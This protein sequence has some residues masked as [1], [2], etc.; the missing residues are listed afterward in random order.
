M[1]EAIEDRLG[2]FVRQ[3]RHSINHSVAVADT[4]DTFYEST[5]A[6]T[7][8]VTAEPVSHTSGQDDSGLTVLAA[9]SHQDDEPFTGKLQRDRG[10]ND[11]YVKLYS[12]ALIEFDIDDAVSDHQLGQLAYAVD[13]QTVSSTEGDGS[14]GKLAL[15]GRVYE[16]LDSTVKVYVQGILR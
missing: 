15:A 4:A 6:Q 2:V 5:L 3:L 8:G 11:P 10:G 1:A 13:N 9:L 14:G 7:D 16:V 12:G